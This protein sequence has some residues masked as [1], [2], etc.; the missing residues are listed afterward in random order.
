MSPCC[1]QEQCNAFPRR[2][3]KKAGEEDFLNQ[4][5]LTGRHGVRPEQLLRGVQEG[6]VEGRLAILAVCVCVPARVHQGG[7]GASVPLP[8]ARTA[9]QPCTWFLCKP[10]AKPS[11]GVSSGAHS[12]GC[13]VTRG[14][15]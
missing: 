5:L 6:L 15:C 7:R 1:A 12:G 14:L 8:S 11:S 10:Q 9:S 3:R 2:Q 13:Q 4:G